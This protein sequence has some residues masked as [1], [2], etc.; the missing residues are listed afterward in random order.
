MHN[1]HNWRYSENSSACLLKLL[2]MEFSGSEKF[3][4]I[5]KLAFSLVFFLFFAYLKTTFL[6]PLITLDRFDSKQALAFLVI[7]VHFT[8]ILLP[9]RQTFSTFYWLSTKPGF[10]F[11]ISSPELVHLN[12]FFFFSI[13]FSKK[14]TWPTYKF[15]WHDW[16]FT[17][18]LASNTYIKESQNYRG[19]KEPLEYIE[20]NL[21]IYIYIAPDLPL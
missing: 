20:F 13:I 5:H 7:S 1:K 11:S 16:I 6:L 2:S 9:S 10:W 3:L 8:S 19:W 21:Q 12:C 18:G 14:L 17:K 4:T 15:T